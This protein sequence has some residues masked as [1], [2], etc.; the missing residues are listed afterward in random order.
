MSAPA[1]PALR[2]DAAPAATAR[3]V[4]N[5]TVKGLRLVWAHRTTVI[6]TAVSML[7]FYLAVQYFI[8]GGRIL[9]TLVAQTA[10][11]FFAYIV[12]YVATMRM[13]AGILEERN[14]GTLEQTLL[15]PLPA[16]R[17]VAGRMAAA[18]IEA[19]AVAGVAVAGV[20]VARGVAY[21]AAAEA[22]VPAVLGLAGLAGFA[23]LLAAASFTF[24]GI[25]AIVHVVQMLVFA[26]NGTLVPTELFPGWLR[27]IAE[28]TPSTLAV[29][30]TRD[31]LLDGASL[32]GLWQ[33]GQLVWL[34]AH[35]VALVLLG[36][37]AYQVQIRRALRDGRLGPA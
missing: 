31:A 18:M 22:L 32:A 11:G 4:G 13:V 17:L 6:A 9:D 35:T 16:G 15:S 20:L 29:G 26:L 24:P 37:V 25:G 21:P 14:A 2:R 10:P 27:L 1:I 5:E 36:W 12:A 28:L 3:I 30:A 23:L 33:A 8:G 7:G 34:A 19:V